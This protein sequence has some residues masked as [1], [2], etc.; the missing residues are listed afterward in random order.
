MLYF[1]HSHRVAKSIASNNINPDVI[2]DLNLNNSYWV[3]Y[4]LRPSNPVSGA[5]QAHNLGPGNPTLSQVRVN[6]VLDND[7]TVVSDGPFFDLTV[8]L[9]INR[10]FLQMYCQK[11]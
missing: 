10:L 9:F 2:E 3:M 8:P 5:L 11:E 4:G 6:A 7:T 1:F